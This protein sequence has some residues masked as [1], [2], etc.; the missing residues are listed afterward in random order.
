[1]QTHGRAIFSENVLYP[2][3]LAKVLKMTDF[4]FSSGW[5]AFS[6]MLFF[7][8]PFLIVF[9]RVIYKKAFVNT[10]PSQTA[11]KKYS[12]L[13]AIWIASTIVLFVLVNVISINYMPPISTAQASLIKDIKEVDVTARSWSYDI[14][15]RTYETGTTV[16]FIAKSVDTIHG[17]AVYHPDG[18][19]LFTM[20]LVPGLQEPTSLTYTFTDPGKYKIRC[21]E[22][23]GVVHHAMRDELTVLPKG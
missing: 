21:S 6:I 11:S 15:E 14:S 10:Q 8:I 18:R 12:T 3:R 4:L 16:R 7:Q 9:I 22:Y 2:V 1:M 17:F 19:I 20:M 5:G 23:C 13:E